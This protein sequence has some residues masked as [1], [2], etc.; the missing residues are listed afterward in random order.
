[1]N[2]QIQALCFK[3]KQCFLGK[4]YYNTGTNI[5]KSST[6]LPPQGCAIRCQDNNAQGRKLA[7][8]EGI[9]RNWF[10]VYANLQGP[11]MPLCSGQNGGLWLPDNKW[12]LDPGP[13]YVGCIRAAHFPCDV[14][15]SWIYK[16]NWHN[17]Q[18]QNP[19]L[20]TQTCG[21]KT[22]VGRTRLPFPTTVVNQ[23]HCHVSGGT[24]KFSSTTTY[25]KDGGD[26]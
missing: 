7:Q 17:Q 2:S 21:V 12:S 1:M 16:E 18:W 23:G 3:G 9:A 25:I 5:P 10:W 15:S 14:P 24:G 22:T 6:N 4:E 26:S 13:P 19:L 20:D 11:Q 8:F